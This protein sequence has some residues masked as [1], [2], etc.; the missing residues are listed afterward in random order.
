MVGTDPQ[1]GIE[2]RSLTGRIE[3]SIHSQRWP[4]P[5]LIDWSADD[6]AVIVDHFGLVHS[7]SGPIGVTLLRVALDGTVQPLWDTRAGRHAWGIYSPD[8]GYLA[9]R[10]PAVERNVWM[11]ENF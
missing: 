6:T 10:A 3:R 2:V 9:I 5:L 7:P 1:G 11:V 4:N 8:G